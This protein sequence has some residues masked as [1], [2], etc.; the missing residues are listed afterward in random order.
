MPVQGTLGPVDIAI[1]GMRAQGTQMEIISS[2]I[3]SHFQIEFIFNINFN[4]EKKGQGI[5]HIV[6]LTE[7]PELVFKSIQIPEQAKH[8]YLSTQ[9]LQ[10]HGVI[11]GIKSAVV[12]SPFI[13]S[14]AQHDAV[15]RKISEINAQMLERK[16]KYIIIV[17]GRLGSKNTNWGIY[18]DYKDVDGAVAI[19][20]YGVDIAGRAEPVSDEANMSGG[21]YGSHFLYMIQGGFDEEQKRIQTRMYGTQGTHFLTNLVGNNVIYS[22]IN[23][24]KDKVDHWLFSPPGNNEPIYVLKFPQRAT[25]YADSVKQKCVLLSKG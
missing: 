15:S 19:F 20:E 7:L 23:P 2:N 16:E 14:K 5:F 8:T 3:S 6:Q 12:V 25:I 11:R 24:L 18:A 4:R 22:Y 13:Y 1:S 10:G 21:I 17:P 9:N